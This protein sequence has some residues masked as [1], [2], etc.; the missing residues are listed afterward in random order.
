MKLLA[1]GK[2]RNTSVS[3]CHQKN[4]TVKITISALTIFGCIFLLGCTIQQAKYYQPAIDNGGRAE[5]IAINPS[6]EKIIY[7]ASSS[8]GLFRSV[9]AGASWV[10]VPSLTSY[11]V[12]D[13]EFSPDGLLLASS[14]EGGYFE[15]KS[16]VRLWDVNTGKAIAEFQ[17]NDLFQNFLCIRFSPDG[18]VLASGSSNKI[19]LWDIKTLEEIKTLKGHIGVVSSIHF[20]PDGSF[21]S[22]ASPLYCFRYHPVSLVSAASSRWF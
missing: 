3:G 18:N 21:L 8:G 6:N 1:C 9:D 17:G 16:T 12:T 2:D 15:G 13:V 20:S 22:S 5:A 11:M 19:I 7:V 10:T 14:N 4:H